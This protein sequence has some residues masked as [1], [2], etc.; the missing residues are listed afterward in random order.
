M[1]STILRY[2][3]LL[4]PFNKAEGIGL[5]SCCSDLFLCG[6]KFVVTNI[7]TERSIE[8]SGLLTDDPE[9]RTQVRDVKVTNVYAVDSDRALVREVETLQQLYYS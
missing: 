9:A 7:L 2:Y 6:I 8:K 1:L 5:S 3:Q 4:V